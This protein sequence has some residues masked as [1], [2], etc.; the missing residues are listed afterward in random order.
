MFRRS[1]ARIAPGKIQERCTASIVCACRM[2]L[3]STPPHVASNHMTGHVP[4]G[5]VVSG[6][7]LRFVRQRAG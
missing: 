6:A 1:S 3:D 7:R 2:D 5:V 4:A